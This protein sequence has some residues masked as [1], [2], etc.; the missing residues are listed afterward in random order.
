MYWAYSILLFL[1]L[2]YYIPV[3]FFKLR[4]R[5]GESLYF[6]QRFGLKLPDMSISGP[7]IWIHAVS[8]GEVL[9]LQN[10]INKF[11]ERNPDWS[12]Y[13]SVLTNSGFKIA[14]EKLS[15]IS[16]VFFI[17]FDFTLIIKRFFQAVKPDL[18]I[19]AE[20]EFW[21]NLLKEANK[22][23][24]AV[25]LINGRVSEKTF[26]WF[27]RMK[28][29][30]KKILAN[31]DFFLVQTER[32][33]TGL[34]DLGIP[35]SKV[36]LA[37]NLKTEIQ[38]PLLSSKKVARFKDQLGI[39]EGKKVILAGS[40]HRGEE[41]QILQAFSNAKKEYPEEVLMIAPRHPERAGEIERICK[42]LFLSCVR[43]SKNELKAGWDVLIIDTL[44]ELAVLYSLCDLAFIGGSLV[45]WGGQN[46]LEP[47]FYG[48]PIFFGPHMNNFKDIAEIFV[49]SNSASIVKNS[50]EL[51]HI[52]QF[53]DR[54]FLTQMGKNARST[55]KSLQ[56]A[57]E[58]TLDLIEKYTKKQ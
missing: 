5:K 20:S 30:V 51:D 39:P 4:L 43:K 7:S 28:F 24:T 38:L 17:P 2:F 31:I 50:A 42:D 6:N 55:L 29:F 48:K 40:T 25:L 46:I 37:G 34:I 54:D 22:N 11:K 52:F 14:S 41:I 13:I 33:K 9:S 36:S 8:V 56:G 57:T 53:Q 19:L 32:E 3:Y 45:E 49:R 18:F 16:G 47:A 27:S 15:N 1:S 21:P 26:R 44:G 35:Q 10:L 58:K 23:C 12:V